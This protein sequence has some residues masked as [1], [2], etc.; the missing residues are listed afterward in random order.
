MGKV[1][2]IWQFMTYVTCRC[3]YFLQILYTEDKIQPQ[4]R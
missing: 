4:F 2:A 3:M 1:D